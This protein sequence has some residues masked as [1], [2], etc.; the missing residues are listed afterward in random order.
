MELKKGQ[1]VWIAEQ[2]YPW[3]VVECVVDTAFKDGAVVSRLINGEAWL[4]TYPNEQIFEKEFH[5]RNRAAANCQSKIA[6]LQNM[7]FY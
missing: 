3:T 6:E 4:H 5:A 1:A 7:K 2:E